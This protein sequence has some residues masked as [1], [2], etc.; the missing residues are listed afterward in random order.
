[1][2]KTNSDKRIT[3]D[4]ESLSELFTFNKGVSSD[5]CNNETMALYLDKQLTNQ[6]SSQS[7]VEI[8]LT[9]DNK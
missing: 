4:D 2:L 9:H 1:M 6:A 8:K 7:I 5:E 3:I